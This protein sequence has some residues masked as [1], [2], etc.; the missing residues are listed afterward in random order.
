MNLSEDSLSF[1]S[2]FVADVWKDDVSRDHVDRDGR[3]WDL[4]WFSKRIGH[5]VT[6]EEA[7]EAMN[8]AQ[9]GLTAVNIDMV[10]DY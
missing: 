5:R 9:K 6:A 2:R 8:D 4:F 1:T 10:C 3:K 7:Y